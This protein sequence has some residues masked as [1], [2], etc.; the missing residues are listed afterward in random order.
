MVTRDDV[1]RQAGVSPSTVSYVINNGPRSVSDSTKERVQKAINDLGYRP[2]AVARN[3]RR[4]RTSSLG[5]I[6]PDIINPYFA[7]VAQGIEAVAFER[8]FTVVFCHTKY[9]ID[10]ELKY[11]DHLYDER[12]AG[13]LWV[14][15]TG[16]FEPAQR[17]LD[18][19]LPVV[20]MDRV[21]DGIQ[22]PAVVA[23][24]Y[25]GGYIATEHLLSLGHR[26][27]GCIARPVR[28]SH[29]LE[30]VQGYQAALADAGIELDER[31]V[32]AG[33]FRLENGY[34]AIQYLLDLDDPPTAVFTYNDIMAIGA[35][36]ALKER[37]FEVPRDFSVVGYDDIPDAAYTCPA[38]TTVRQAKYE[39]GA[40]GIELLIKIMDGEDVDPR[41][42]ERVDVE[43]IVRETTGPLS[44]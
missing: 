35:I 42:E 13:V 36:R 8:D 11:L 41:T 33:G 18:Y 29:S 19:G 2:N 14:P 30:R 12:A 40:K 25:R 32:A 24:N 5:L 16:E 3:L 20:L 27:I 10:Q 22:I 31:L 34:E 26:R 23:D 6:I 1:A 17:L 44:G 21:L 15:A 9:S 4:Q 7:Q 43:L 38:L 39:M 28:L 37:G